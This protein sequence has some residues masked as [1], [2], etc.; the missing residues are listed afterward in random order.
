MVPGLEV[1]VMEAS[2]EEVVDIADLVAIVPV[3]FPR[4]HFS[5]T[6]LSRFK[7]VLMVLERMTPR[8]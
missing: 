5:L 2:E 1:R 6:S 3:Y 7:E 8:A 4:L